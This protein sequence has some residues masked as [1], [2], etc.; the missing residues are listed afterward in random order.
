MARPLSLC[1]EI[2]KMVACSARHT[3]VLTSLGL[4]YSCGDNTE[5]ALGSGD[6]NSRHH[7][8]VLSQWYTVPSTSTTS[9]EAEATTT[10][11]SEPK[12]AENPPV[13]IKIAAAAGIIGSHSVALD[14]N[15]NLY[16]W[17]F[18]Q[19][20]GHGVVKPVTSPRQ[21]DTFPIPQSMDKVREM[22]FVTKRP[23]LV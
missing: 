12:L 15:G 4:V 16:S 17:G 23:I 5:G 3:L 10:T 13:I 9:N 21:I 19:A 8:H 7:L 14:E 22:C 2:V 6:V 20:T 18:A 1:L 11:R